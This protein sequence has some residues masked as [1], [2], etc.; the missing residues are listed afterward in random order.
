VGLRRGWHC[1]EIITI[2]PRSAA[3]CGP[4]V[5]LELNCR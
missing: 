1:L 2:L 5:E 3:C 4:P